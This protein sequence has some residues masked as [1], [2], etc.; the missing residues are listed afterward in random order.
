V[1]SCDG[2]LLTDLPYEV[3]VALHDTQAATITPI[4]LNDASGGLPPRSGRVIYRVHV[5]DPSAAACS[6]SL[7][8]RCQI[9]V[10][11]D[12]LI[13][14]GLPPITTVGS[15]PTPSPTGGLP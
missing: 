6:A 11:V 4:F 1:P 9:A 3:L 15:G 12:A 10:V 5:H 14:Q 13:W 2:I 8:A 7:L